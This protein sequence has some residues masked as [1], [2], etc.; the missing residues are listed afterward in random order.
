MVLNQLNVSSYV[1]PMIYP[2]VILSLPR[3]INKSI[4]LLMAFGMGLVI[5][6]FMNTGGANTIALLVLAY[7][8]SSFLSSLGP[9][10]MG[11]EN[12]R[13]SITS[14]GLKNYLTYS[15]LL[16][17]I[18]HLLFFYLEIFSFSQFLPT[19]LRAMISLFFS[20][21]LVIIYQYLFPINTK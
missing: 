4:L 21:I 1:F 5:D 6:L 3:R 8:R 9:M 15:L 2:I 20:W 11:S 17:L 10:D 13:P 18:H 14:L 7:V 12:I 19:L 16:L